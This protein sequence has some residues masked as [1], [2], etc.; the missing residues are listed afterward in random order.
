MKLGGSVRWA[1]GVILGTL[2]AGCAGAGVNNA[3]TRDPDVRVTDQRLLSVPFFP[4]N[5]DQCGPSSLASVLSFWG[6]PTAPGDLKSEI[7]LAQVKGS[8]PMDLMLAAQ[9]RG[10]KAHL[11]NGSLEDVKVELSRG[12]PLVAF[13]NRGFLF[14]PM[15]HFVVVSGFDEVRQGFYVHSGLS[16][17]KF[18]RYGS[19]WRNWKKTQQT[20]LL[21]L[22]PDRDQESLHAGP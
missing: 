8:L 4:D 16:K 7:Y 15:G 13:L 9:N 10:F 12:H 18:M 11:Y 6:T 19:F 14:A 3:P 2:A 1:R 5:T 20:T 22:P 17:N 21:I